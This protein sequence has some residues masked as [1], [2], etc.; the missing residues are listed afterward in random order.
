MRSRWENLPTEPDGGEDDGVEECICAPQQH[1]GYYLRV[2]KM[3]Q[4]QFDYRDCDREIWEEELADFVPDRIFDAH[5]HLFW[6]SN[7][8]QVMPGFERTDTD[9]QTLNQ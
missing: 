2:S 9:L 6:R 5:I 3:I 1:V 8:A 4:A 7:V